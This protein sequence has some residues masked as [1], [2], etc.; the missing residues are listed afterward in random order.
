ML[1]WLAA[2][3]HPDGRIAFFNDAAFG[4]AAEPAALAEYAATLG[5]APA[6]SGAPWLRDSGYVRLEAGEAVSLI[7]IAPVGPDHLPGHAHADTLSFELSLGAERLVVNGGSSVYGEGPRRAFE[8]STAAASTVEVD[9]A[10]SSEMWAG[11]RVGRRARVHDPRVSAEDGAAEVSASHDGYRHLPGR[12]EH[13]RAWRLTADSLVI[14]DRIEGRFE[15]AVA[16]FH[17]A[18][19]VRPSMDADGRSGVLITASGRSVRWSADA[20]ASLAPFAWA[21]RFGRREPTS[22]LVLPV[23]PHGLRTR[24]SW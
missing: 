16:R 4:I 13:R 17:L 7:D 1:A 8:R 24:L 10:S 21:C 22:S 9:G 19:G 2:M 18:P 20:P 11:F 14:E 3:I 5:V 15:T 6:P 12:P 23:G